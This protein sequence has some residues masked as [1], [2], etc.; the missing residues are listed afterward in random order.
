MGLWV[1][2]GGYHGDA[3]LWCVCRCGGSFNEAI[4]GDSQR[5]INPSQDE[6]RQVCMCMCM[7]VYVCMCVLV[8]EGVRECM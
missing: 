2:E 3:L 5:F 4:V 7:Y 6:E 8:W 1:L